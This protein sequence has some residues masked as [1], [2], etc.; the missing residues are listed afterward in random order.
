MRGSEPGRLRLERG[1]GVIREDGQHV[2]CRHDADDRSALDKGHVPHAFGAHAIRDVS[3]GFLGLGEHEVVGHDVG[4]PDLVSVGAGRERTHNVAFGH[5]AHRAIGPGH[6]CDADVELGE[7]R[8]KRSQRQLLLDRDRPARHDLADVI[9]RIRHD[10][11]FLS[12]FR[13]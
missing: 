12:G 4:G 8:G 9:V 3:D 5:D 1:A 10:R 6:D 2:A 7:N 13:V 11:H